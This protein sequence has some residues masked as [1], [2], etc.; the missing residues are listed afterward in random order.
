MPENDFFAGIDAQLDTWEFRTLADAFKPR[1]PLQYAI[2]GLFTLPS[3]TIVFGAPGTL[4]SMLLGS[5]ALHVAG[6]LPW[7]GRKVKAF[8]TMWLDMDNGKRRTDERFEA[9]ARHLGLNEGTPFFYISMPTPMFNAG[10]TGDTEAMVNRMISRGIKLLFIDNLGLIS[11]GADENSDAMVKVMGN[12]RLLA[13]RT[14]AAVVIIH[15]QRKKSKQTQTARTGETLR[16]HSSI[17]ASL[18]LALLVEREFDSDIITVHSTKTRDT[19]VRPFAAEWRYEHKPGTDE[20]ET[21]GFVSA[22]GEN[23]SETVLEKAIIETVSSNALINQ[24]KLKD[25]VMKLTGIGRNQV[26]NMIR[27]LEVRK[28]LNVKPGSNN[29]K[30]YYI[31]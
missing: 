31:E 9:L 10:D 29:E 16:G 26:I 5:A 7:L 13:E 12:L 25:D 30:L 3:L 18:D 8:P 14:D 2:T 27:A 4:K 19:E 24:T 21:A 22:E 11:P 1:P 6:G 20:L 15:H 28:A 23:S 17:E